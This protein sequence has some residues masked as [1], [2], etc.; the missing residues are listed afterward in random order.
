MADDQ[1]PATALIRYRPK[2]LSWSERV[3]TYAHRLRASLVSP[4]WWVGNLLLIG[5][6]I[7]VGWPVYQSSIKRGLLHTALA[8]GLL[9]GRAWRYAAPRTMQ[10]VPIAY[11][12]R[13]ASLYRLIKDMQRRESMTSAEILRFQCETL[14]LIASY[15]RSHRAD[16][17]GTE[18]FTNL[19]IED[20][21]HLKVIARNFDHRNPDARYPK[22]DMLATSAIEHGE[23]TWIGDL[24]KHFPSAAGKRYKSILVLPII[25]AHAVLGAVSIDSTRKHHFDLEHKELE[26]YLAP[27]V[28][29]LAWT[30]E[31]KVPTLKNGE[32]VP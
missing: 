2:E 9:V 22:E 21:D 29:L 27:Y 26:R 6:W 30:L 15:V 32:R 10:P 25:G 8:I 18:I 31:A 3:A 14:V 13:K 19:L 28:C 24:A 11:L 12:E 16:T 1:L 20:G 7:A 17:A 4:L 23:V 5:F